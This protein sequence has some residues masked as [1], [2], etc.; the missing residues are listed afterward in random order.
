VVLAS[1]GTVTARPGDASWAAVPVAAIAEVQV[2][3]V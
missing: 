1:A 3:F 2:E